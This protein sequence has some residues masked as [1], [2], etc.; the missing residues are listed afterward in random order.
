MTP[1]TLAEPGRSCLALAPW[2]AL[3]L[4][5][6]LAACAHAPDATPPAP[7]VE[8]PRRPALDPGPT[9]TESDIGALSQEDVEDQFKALRP[10]LI[11]C[12]RETTRRL[13]CAGGRIAVRIRVDRQGSVRWVWLT[14]STLGDRDA[15]RCVLDVVR[16]RTWPRPLS[17][18]GL[19]ES[20]FEVEPSEPPAPWPSFKALALAERAS[21]ATRTCRRGVKGTF[22]ATAYV[23]PK[24]EVLLAGVAPPN[25][26]GEQ[27]S[28]CIAQAL[29]GMQLAWLSV[30]Q[31]AT[32]K[33]SFALR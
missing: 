14:D 1:R 28:D 10:E 26:D 12:V 29:L 3:A 15:E 24:G 2:V 4:L 23:S 18:D 13:P 30:G 32:A 20:S 25:P 33:V 27:A 6:A 16:G 5:A 19:A 9:S 21:S 8:K 17:G 22:R 11:R 7:A 31:R